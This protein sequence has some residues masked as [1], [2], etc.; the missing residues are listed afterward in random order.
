MPQTPAYEE[1]LNLVEDRS[2]ALRGSVAAFP[3]PDVRVPSCPDWS[4]RELVEHLTEVQRFWAA[5]V[6]AGPS[7]KPP[8]VAPADDAAP[9][10]LLARS[11]SATQELI[12]ALRSVDP[13]AGC[14]TWWDG[15]GVPMTTGAVAR[16]QVQEAAVHAFDAQLATGTPEPVPAV[17]AL[18]GIAEFIGV[19]HGTASPW[20][21][22]PARIGLHT[23]EGASWL[24]DLTQSGSTVVD[25]PDGATAHLHGPA[26]DL[27]LVLHGRLPLD[28]LRSEGD[29]ATLERLLSWPDLD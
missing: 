25:D 29:R 27:L 19:S 13:A 5:A 24:I 3:D 18:D 1:L 23:T 14:W 8:T 11:A 6:V 12:A 4:L 28:Q 21:H 20:P 22:E 16:H 26:S 17:V 2:A 10:D 15:S 9:S 7:E